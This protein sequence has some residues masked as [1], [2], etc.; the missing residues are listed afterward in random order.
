MTRQETIEEIEKLTAEMNTLSL[1]RLLD[2]AR[3]LRKGQNK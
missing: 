1:L 3:A 2:C